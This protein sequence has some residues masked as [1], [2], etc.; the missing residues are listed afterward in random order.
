MH[1]TTTTWQLT[2]EGRVYLV[3]YTVCDDCLGREIAALLAQGQSERAYGAGKGA[4]TLS[5]QAAA[6]ET[7]T[8]GTGHEASP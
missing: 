8:T 3:A 2:H 1:E 6:P 4:F 5:V 7:P